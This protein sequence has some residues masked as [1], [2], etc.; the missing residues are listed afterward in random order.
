MAVFTTNSYALGRA[1]VAQGLVDRF[2]AAFERIARARTG[3]VRPGL[4]LEL[5]DEELARQ[6][7]TRRQ[8]IDAAAR[9]LT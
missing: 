7:L 4:M 6:G 3:H 9:A 1:Q 2:S 8:V 5:S